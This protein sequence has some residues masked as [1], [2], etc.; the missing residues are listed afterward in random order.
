MS[1]YG[2]WDLRIW[3]DWSTNESQRSKW[4]HLFPV[5]K[6]CTPM[7]YIVGEY[8][9]LNLGLHVC[10]A[11]ILLTE[12]SLGLPIHHVDAEITGFETR[13]SFDPL[14]TPTLWIHFTDSHERCKMFMNAHHNFEHTSNQQIEF[15]LSSLKRQTISISIEN[16]FNRSLMGNIVDT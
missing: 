2:D 1:L 5:G 8:W 4:L 13:H 10:E 9:Q 6:V 16:G 3:L 7:S 11:S 14:Q 12:L 15:S